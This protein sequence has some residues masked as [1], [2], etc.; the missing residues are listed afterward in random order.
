MIAGSLATHALVTGGDHVTY[1]NPERHEIPL[2]DFVD[3]QEAQWISA[4][5]TEGLIA[6]CGRSSL[7]LV[8]PHDGSK[9]TAVFEDEDGIAYTEDGSYT[10]RVELAD[11][12]L[13]YREGE[14]L[15]TA[16]MSTP[17]QHPELFRPKLVEEF[18]AEAR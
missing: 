11:R 12:Y 18:F 8:R 17:S 15:R 6:L 16:K 2:D 4:G 3:F 1:F 5:K 7:V 9:L 13:A 14:D 10:G